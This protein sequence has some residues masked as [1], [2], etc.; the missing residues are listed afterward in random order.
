MVLESFHFHLQTLEQLC[1]PALFYFMI[2]VLTLLHLI[3]HIAF[4]CE[5]CL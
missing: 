3:L 4:I 2:K 5:L 1:T